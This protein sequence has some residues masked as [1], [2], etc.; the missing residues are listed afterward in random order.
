MMVKIG[1]KNK[2]ITESGHFLTNG[3]TLYLFI[4]FLYAAYL[5]LQTTM[6]PVKGYL[7]EDYIWTIVFV[8]I[9]FKALVL[10]EWRYTEAIL[11]VLLVGIGMIVDYFGG[12]NLPFCQVMLIIGA[13]NVDYRKILSVHLSV[14]LVVVVSAVFASMTGIIE[15]LQYIRKGEIRNSFGIVYPTDFGAQLFFGYL[16][17]LAI[18]HSVR[19]VWHWL[20]GLTLAWFIYVYCGARWNA[21]MLV[22]CV[23]GFILLEGEG[24][25]KRKK[26]CDFAL[27]WG[28]ILSVP[29]IAGVT[30]ANIRM[31]GLK[32][33]FLQWMIR[34][35]DSYGSR[36][37]ISTR[38]LRRYPI[39]LWG[40][41]VQMQ[42]FGGDVTLPDTIVEMTFLDISY[43]NILLRFGIVFSAALFVVYVCICLRYRC[44][45]EILLILILV[46]LSGFMEHHIFELAYN[47]FFLL[48]FAKGE[49]V[50]EDKRLSGRC[51]N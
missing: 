37:E 30:A 14:R 47:P 3:E 4:I 49:G 10:D 20:A 19:R 41:S 7:Q 23:L 31:S 39:S 6:F 34:Y 51:G 5:I 40:Q 24:L 44:R 48:L 9:V 25:K 18:T 21:G 50:D 36:M 28:S 16:T 12:V 43:V 42:G 46:A 13:K 26:H 29:V 11:A 8:G 17:F 1:H 2:I 45:R 38:M 33:E 22:A 15:N 27:L 35:F 32:Q